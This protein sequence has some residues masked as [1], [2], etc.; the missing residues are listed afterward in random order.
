[1]APHN[2]KVAYL[3]V[4]VTARGRGKAVARATDT[5]GNT[6]VVTEIY[7]SIGRIDVGAC[8]HLHPLRAQHSLR[9]VRLGLRLYGG[10]RMTLPG[11]SRSAAAL[12]ARWS[13][14]GRRRLRR[15]DYTAE[16]PAEGCRPVRNQ[17]PY[18]ERS[19]GDVIRS[20]TSSA[21]AAAGATR[22]TGPTSMRSA[23]RRVK[24]VASR[25]D[26][27]WSRDVLRKYNLA[28]RCHA[29][30]FSPFQT[31]RPKDVVAWLLGPS[32]GPFQLQM[33]KFIWPGQKGV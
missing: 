23:A 31:H 5:P 24:F 20:W 22:T 32:R 4:V 19:P 12:A 13:D 2:T 33:H 3:I 27:E 21:P 29:S 6:L 30:C 7:R 14:H 16:G 8:L 25:E 17:R 28:A 26:Y 9:L 15:K 1:M 10:V 18:P 11:S